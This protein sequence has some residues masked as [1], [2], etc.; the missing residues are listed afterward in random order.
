M[1]VGLILVGFVL[2]YVL[3]KRLKRRSKKEI[4][5]TRETFIQQKADIRKRPVQ[6]KRIGLEEKIDKL[7][8]EQTLVRKP[9]N[10]A[11]REMLV[12]DAYEK[13]L[14]IND[15]EFFFHE[16]DTLFHDLV[17][18]LKKRYPDLSDKQLIWCCLHLLKIPTHDMLILLDYK[19][20]NSLKRMKNRLADRMGVATAAS[21]GTFLLSIVSED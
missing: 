11:E 3:I 15:L 4:K 1:A 6:K 21:L 17:S 7:K 13:L 2:A 10:Q 9:C 16:M 14:H 12:R 5:Q 20:D 18:K 19:T 8:S